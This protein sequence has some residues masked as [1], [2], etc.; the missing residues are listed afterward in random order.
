MDWREFVETM[1]VVEQVLKRD[2]ADVYGRMDFAT[3]DR[4][5]HVI[6]RLAKQ[7]RL[8]EPEVARRAIQLAGDAAAARGSASREAHVGYYLIDD[9][10]PRLER[11][12]Q[13]RLSP[14]DWS[15]R[16]FRRHALPVYVGA[17]TILTTAL[18]AGL[19]AQALAGG[20]RGWWL[21]LF[22]ALALLCA[23]HLA[24]ALV[25]WLTTLLVTPHPLPRL[26][27]SEGI[28]P[29]LRTLVA[30]PTMLT[31]EAEIES[32][33]EALEVRYLANRDD[34]LHFA[35]L[36]DLCDADAETLPEDGPLLQLADARIAALNAKYPRQV[37]S[38]FYLLHRPRLWN[39][40]DRVWMGYE[41]KRGKLA[42]LNALLRGGTEGRFSL[43]G[44]DTSALANVR[45]V[46]TLDSDTELARDSA[47][48]FVGT[49]AHPL[50]RPLFDADRGRV[51]RGYSILQPRVAAGLAG[52]NRS[53]YARLCASELGIDPYTRAA[54]DVYQDLFGEGSFIGKG[55]YEVE[56]FEQTMNGR[57]PE[58]RI[59]SHDLLEGC[60]GRSGLLS[61]VQLF[62]DYPPRY[63]ADTARRWRWIRGDWQIAQ[64]LLPVV[65]GADGRLHR[66]VLSPL[67]RWKIIDNLR[68][69]LTA[70][71]L[72]LLL[73]LGWTA[74]PGAWFWTLAV[75]AILL[76]SAG[77]GIVAQPAA[78][79]A[80]RHDRAASDRGR[81]GCSPPPRTRGLPVRLPAARGALQPRCRRAHELAAVGHA[82]L[83]ASVATVVFHRPGSPPWVRR[84]AAH[85][86]DRA[87][88]RRRNHDD[89][90]GDTACRVA[91]RLA[92]AGLLAGVAGRGLVGEP[93]ARATA[94]AAR[95]RA[96]G[97]PATTGAAYLVVL[98]DLRRPGGPL[99]ATR[100][101]PGAPGRQ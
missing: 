16:K 14:G 50:N 40:R 36:T 34:H 61:D 68:R 47:C 98:R 22:G 80:R 88:P 62:E 66:N 30:V 43:I 12:A 73:L 71:A 5:R 42:D 81:R 29:E 44:G 31:G 59:L 100:Q 76:G 3:R 39:P 67:S 57:F 77:A 72:T 46:I 23:S 26:D 53:R 32:L 85:H 8:E 4:Y 91:G 83:A 97:L 70:A 49:M 13:A 19:A 6:E 78:Q 2:P 25:N 11:A 92:G 101:F 56:T 24:F 60:Y 75:V 9:G 48:R 52:T 93:S 58:N 35:L 99:A 86:V 37:G 51:V 96:A 94:G 1:S 18:G 74:L 15:Q 17:I 95:S 64:W 33:V 79:A 7:G 69:S 55:I 87:V 90:G 45:Y 54:S 63:A 65:P 21:G 84:V 89:P 41:R 28:P 82:S 20:L 38:T 27:L 10:L